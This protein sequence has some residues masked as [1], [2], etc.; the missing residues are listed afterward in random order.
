MDGKEPFPAW[1]EEKEWQLRYGDSANGGGSPD[2]PHP[3][4]TARMPI[5]RC[6]HHWQEDKVAGYAESD[7]GRSKL[8]GFPLVLNVGY[9]GNVFASP[10]W[11]EGRPDVGDR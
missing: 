7:K 2:N 9:A 10:P 1:W 11:W 4:S 8:R 5:I 6:W 3:Y